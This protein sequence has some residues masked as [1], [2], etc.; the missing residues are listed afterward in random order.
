M[1]DNSRLKKLLSPLL[2]QMRIDEA[3]LDDSFNYAFEVGDSLTVQL[4]ENPDNYLTVS[5][6]LPMR[7][8]DFDDP[9]RLALLLQCNVLGLEHPPI[10][11]GTL[12]EQQKLIL[13]TRLMFSELEAPQLIRLF[14][15][16]VEQATLM[17]QWLQ[18]PLTETSGA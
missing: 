11:T 10:L 8:D 5:C 1:A 2:R 13:W 7:P 6:L 14:E 3:Q 12:I 17:A 9:Q 4:E 16:F 18:Q 15:R